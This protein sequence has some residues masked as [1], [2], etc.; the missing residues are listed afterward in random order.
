ME[1]HR[2]AK[3]VLHQ[4]L[5]R[6]EKLERLEMIVMKMPGTGVW[7]NQ[8]IFSRIISAAFGLNFESSIFSPR[9]TVSMYFNVIINWPS[10]GCEPIPMHKTVAI[11]QPCLSKRFAAPRSTKKNNYDEDQQRGE[12]KP[13]RHYGCTMPFVQKKTS[14]QVIP[15]LQRRELRTVTHEW[16]TATDIM[17]FFPHA[18]FPVVGFWYFSDWTIC[19]Q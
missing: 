16:A 11:C 7:F 4:P 9:W 19:V 3:T 8:Q 10:Y 5:E 18:S 15:C 14:H 2:S 12:I 6:L 1:H 17:L 13:R